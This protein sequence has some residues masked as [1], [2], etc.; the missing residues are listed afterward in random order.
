[1][2]LFDWVSNYFDKQAELL[3][4][5]RKENQEAEKKWLANP[6]GMDPELQERLVAEGEIYTRLQISNP[7]SSDIP[8]SYQET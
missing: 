8:Y 4:Q 3:E 1:M 2:G 6:Y 5:A 7:G